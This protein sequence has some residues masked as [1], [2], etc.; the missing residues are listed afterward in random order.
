MKKLL[1]LNFALVFCLLVPSTT[2]A[3]KKK[4]ALR[5]ALASAKKQQKHNTKPTKVV[6]NRQSHTTDKKMPIHPMPVR[7]KWQSQWFRREY[8]TEQT[9]NIVVLRFISS[10]TPK[11][12]SNAIGEDLLKK[13]P[14]IEKVDIN[15]PLGLVSFRLKAQQSPTIAC[16][17]FLQTFQILIIQ[18]GLNVLLQEAEPLARNLPH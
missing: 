14:E 10:F 2:E 7:A 5:R 11:L 1:C 15:A 8:Y 13:L 3:A 17:R 9:Q 16:D 4:P 18:K 6:Q 12:S